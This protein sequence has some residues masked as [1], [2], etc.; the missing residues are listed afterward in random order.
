MLIGNPAATSKNEFDFMI[1]YEC[2]HFNV[3]AN[4]FNADEGFQ[5]L[6]QENCTGVKMAITTPSK[7]QILTVGTI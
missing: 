2:Q 4:I 1:S 5:S 3:T 6:P 7:L